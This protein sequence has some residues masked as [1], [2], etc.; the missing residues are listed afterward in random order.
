MST[1][2]KIV[3]SVI[4][5]THNRQ[6]SLQRTLDALAAQTYPAS[7]MEVVVV[8][9]GCSD[10][11]AALVRAYRAPYALRVLEQAGA[12]AGAAR[13]LGAGAASGR[14]LLFLDD[15]IEPLP[16]LVAAHVAAHPVGA[17]RVSLGPSLPVLSGRLDFYRMELRAWWLDFFTA[18]RR[19]GYRFSFRS[20]AAGNC[21]IERELFARIGGFDARIRSCGGEDWELGLRLVKAGV[22]FVYVHAATARHTI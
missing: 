20:L 12:G 3:A 2:N 9:D 17:E 19:P 13:N 15:D 11:S 8:A 22:P 5:P 18:M 16:E 14:I 6:A 7:R 21:A 1:A 4:I 10:G